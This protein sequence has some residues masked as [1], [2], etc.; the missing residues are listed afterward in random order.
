MSMTADDISVLRSAFEHP[1]RGVV[2]LVGDLVTMCR[3]HSLALDWRDGKC[4]VL[5]AG[6]WQELL[7]IRKSIFRAVCAR[8][9]ALCN[10]RTPK[11]VSSSGGEG[12]LSVGSNPST[13]VWVWFTN[14]PAEQMLELMTEASRADTLRACLQEAACSGDM[15]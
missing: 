12:A 3:E 9:A 1:T 6:E 10:E 5:V 2:G 11:S 4:R 14:T 15:P 7:P 8:L 13:V